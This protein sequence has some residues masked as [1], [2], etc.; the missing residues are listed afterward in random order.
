MCN[1]KFICK[2]KTAYEMRISDW[3]SDE[4]AGAEVK[5]AWATY[6]SF[7]P[8][9]AVPLVASGLVKGLGNAQIVAAPNAGGYGLPGSIWTPKDANIDGSGGGGGIGSVSTCHIGDYLK[10][11]PEAELQTT[12][13]S[14]N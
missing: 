2:Q 11:T 3:S 13:R 4:G 1:L 9:A 6:N 14:T 8:S 7:V 10:G 5:E 12:C